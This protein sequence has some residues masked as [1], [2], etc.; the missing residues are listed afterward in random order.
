MK[1]EHFIIALLMPFG[2]LLIAGGAAFQHFQYWAMSQPTSS[3]S[4]N[5]PSIVVAPEAKASEY[6]IRLVSNRPL[7]EVETVY[8]QALN[9]KPQD[10]KPYEVSSVK[11]VAVESPTPVQKHVIESK[12]KNL[13]PESQPVQSVSFKPNAAKPAEQ[14]FDLQ[15]VLAIY[16]DYLMLEFDAS[17]ISEQN[18][19]RALTRV[20]LS[21]EPYAE[22]DLLSLAPLNYRDR[23]AFYRQLLDHHGQPIRYPR[24]AFQYAEYLMRNYQAQITNPQNK[25]LRI[26]VPLHASNLQ[27]PARQYEPWVFQF[28]KDFN[29][30]P[31][32]VF[33]VME[34]ESAFNPFAVSKSNAKGLMQIKPNA[35]GRDVYQYIDFK[36]GAPDDKELFDAQANIRLGTAYLS[37]LKHDY[38][39][40]IRNQEVREMVA[41]S[42]YNGGMSTVLRLFGDSPE[43]AI[44]KINRMSQSRVY[45]TLR[46]EHESD[47]TR[48]YLDKVLQAKARYQALLGDDAQILA[49]R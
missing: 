33:A 44:Q 11:P 20:F 14:V 47:E 3:S 7:P 4:Q 6:Q 24:D 45:K 22:P 31:A 40:G 23:P 16:P 37:L 41:I 46:Y 30:P 9:T 43:K 13:E 21:P 17:L 2:L 29:V 19:K 42:S 1:F 15:P 8:V 27:E 48:R 12:P 26:R 28:A 5:T 10:S 18:V 35:A 38:L 32:L 49:S 25:P 34:T 39:A 36:L